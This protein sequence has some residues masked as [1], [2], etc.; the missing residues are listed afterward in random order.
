MRRLREGNSARTNL[1][2]F[3]PVWNEAGDELDSFKTGC[4]KFCSTRVHGGWLFRHRSQSLLL[5][6]LDSLG[7]FRIAIQKFA[8]TCFVA[9]MSRSCVSS[10]WP[11]A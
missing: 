9:Q 6:R 1:Q 7:G 8:L 4:P 10:C 3:R 11:L 5:P 2:D